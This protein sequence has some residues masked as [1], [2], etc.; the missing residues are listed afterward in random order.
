LIAFLTRDTQEGR[1]FRVDMKLRPWGGQG[2]LVSSVSQSA[3]Y[4]REE[5][6]GWELQAWL[7]ARVCCGAALPGQTVIAAAQAVAGAPENA[8]K[9]VAS[10]RKVR[11]QG[12]DK[13]HRGD[14]RGD[15]LAGEVKLGPGGIRT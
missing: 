13:L 9:V 8:E 3:T 5:A 11:L 1:L 15:Q 7:K 14:A 4:F 6:D 10:M 12:L 2:P